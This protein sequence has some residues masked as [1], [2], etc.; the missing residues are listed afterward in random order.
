M[1][2]PGLRNKLNSGLRRGQTCCSVLGVRVAS[3]AVG[4]ALGAALT[5]KDV[6]RDRLG[7]GAPVAFRLKLLFGM[8]VVSLLVWM[9]LAI[10][11][12][13]AVT[14]VTLW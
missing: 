5:V 13:F 14:M 12:T 10:V 9:P 1:L 4:A 6:V 11:V 2:T 3:A 7:R 8:G